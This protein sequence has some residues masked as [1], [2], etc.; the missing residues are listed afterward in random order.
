MQ[1]AITV[2][3]PGMTCRHSL[4][5]VTASLRDVPGVASIEADVN[6]ATVVV[7]GAMTPPEVLAA[8]DHGGYPGRIASGTGRAGPVAA[9]PTPAARSGEEG[10]RSCP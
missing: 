6:T 5:A 2:R 7:R 8:L 3:V 9:S 1:N 4:R 10:E